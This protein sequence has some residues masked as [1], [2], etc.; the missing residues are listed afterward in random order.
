MTENGSSRHGYAR[1]RRQAEVFLKE[2]KGQ[3]AEIEKHEL[4]ETVHELEV[5]QIELELQN[6]ELRRTAEELEA[7]RNEYFELF[8]SAPVGF[9]I[10]N[11]QG[12]IEQLN[13]VAAGIF[14]RSNGFLIGQPFSNLIHP[15]DLS[16][17]LNLLK[18]SIESGLKGG[19]NSLDLKL[20][21]EDDNARYVRLVVGAKRDTH[22][23]FRQWRLAFTDITQ[24]KE[25]EVALRR[26]HDTLED[27]VSERTVELND[28]K[29]ELELLN[30]NLLKEID[31]RR[32]FEADLKAQGEKVLAAY[33]QRDYLS[34]GLVDLLEKER[35]EMGRTLH[36]EIA[37]IM[38]GVSLQLEGLKETGTEDGSPLAGR[39][40]TIQEHLS[41]GMIQLRN[42]SQNLRSEVLERFGLIPSLK[43][44]AEDMEQQFGFKIHFFT[45][46]VSRYLK[47]PQKALT[48]Y[49]VVQEAL[50][51]IAKHANAQK[52]FI[53]L[54]RTENCVSVTIEDDGKG[55]ES[56][57]LSDHHS[58]HSLLG[59][60]IMRERVSLIGGEFHIES[61]PGKGTHI[62]AE[63]PLDSPNTLFD[64]YGDG[65]CAKKLR[66]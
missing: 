64:K 53:N 66:C 56:D 4:L 31:K 19:K 65:K 44:L 20:W 18:T 50:T 39:L 29:Q 42:I 38:S 63:I 59:I 58:F 41:Q 5:H 27:R 57:T 43:D 37:Q 17:Y 9:V 45:K 30:R 7:A 40:A 14:D 28:K 51:N 11:K 23:V 49:R 33:R 15:D 8:D 55:F 24:A 6:K 12:K 54:K 34:K 35:L 16:R 22:G 25:A 26:A 32:Q 13:K 47:D 36:D 1:L 48:I 3:N 2:K 62:H 46:N 61:E 10:L 52:V 21:K 60:T